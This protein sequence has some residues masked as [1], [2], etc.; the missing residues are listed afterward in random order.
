MAATNLRSSTTSKER[1]RARP[2]QP[3][4]KRRL[5]QAKRSIGYRRV[6]MDSIPK[7]VGT[8]RVLMHARAN[9]L[10]ALNAHTCG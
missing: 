10:R 1:R 7:S 2:T 5:K 4:V 8:G 9:G 6:S 3:R